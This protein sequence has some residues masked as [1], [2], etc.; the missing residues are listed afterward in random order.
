M[1][2]SDPDL[3]TIASTALLESLYTCMHG[4]DEIILVTGYTHWREPARF[5]RVHGSKSHCMLP[6]MSAMFLYLSLIH[7]S[8]PTRPY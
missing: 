3:D 4:N 6:Y 2:Y 1:K 8:E 7:I 5:H